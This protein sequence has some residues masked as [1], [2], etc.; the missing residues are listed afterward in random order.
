MNS[1]C[2][3]DLKEKQ[4]LKNLF[5]NKILETSLLYRASQDGWYARDFHSKCDNK[6]AT[7][8]LFKV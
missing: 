8:T 4:F 2:A 3:N 1:I 7:V 6:G 5:Q